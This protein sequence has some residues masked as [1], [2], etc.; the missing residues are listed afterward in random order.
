MVYFYVGV[1]IALFSLQ[2]Y[3]KKG[4]RKQKK[5]GLSILWV[6][7]TAQCNYDGSIAKSIY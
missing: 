7:G 5:C 2:N 6:D 3:I 1:S 4:G